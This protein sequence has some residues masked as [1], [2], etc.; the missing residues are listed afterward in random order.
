MV[1]KDMNM[2]WTRLVVRTSDA[3]WKKNILEFLMGT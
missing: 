3:G 2:N 1:E